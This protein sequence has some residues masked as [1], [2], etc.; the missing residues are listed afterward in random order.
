MLS[1]VSPSAGRP[2]ATTT[3]PTPGTAA[4][5]HLPPPQTATPA[6]SDAATPDVPSESTDTD[7]PGRRAA[8]RRGTQSPCA[9]TAEQ[10]RDAY[11]AKHVLLPAPC[12]CSERGQCRHRCGSSFSEPERRSINGAVCQLSPNTRRQWFRGTVLV[13]SV[14][15]TRK[16]KD[17]SRSRRTRTYEYSLPKMTEVGIQYRRVCKPFYLT[18]LGFNPCNGGPVAAALRCS[19]GRHEGK[20]LPRKQS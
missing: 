18:T 4:I 8:G 15:K 7:T 20:T 1:D 5:H 9:R 3:P 17:S 12:E 6:R 14:E 16:R 19:E 11:A 13:K 2:P 10:Q